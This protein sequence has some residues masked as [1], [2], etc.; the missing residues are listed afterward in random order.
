MIWST[1]NLVREQ[2]QPP[3]NNMN[4]NHSQIK[5]TIFANNTHNP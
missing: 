4:Y 3:L 1:L 5:P 2:H